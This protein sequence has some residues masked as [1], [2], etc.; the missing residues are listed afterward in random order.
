V[1]HIVFAGSRKQK[2]TRL[3][4]SGWVALLLEDLTRFAHPRTPAERQQQQ[5]QGMESVKRVMV[6][7]VDTE[8]VPWISS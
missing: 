4:R 6:I 3:S 5:R 7:S 2:P 8:P 1:A